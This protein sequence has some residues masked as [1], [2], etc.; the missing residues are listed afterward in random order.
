[1]ETHE[2]MQALPV[3]RIELQS[4]VFAGDGFEHSLR[5]FENRRST[6]S[7]AETTRQILHILR[8]KEGVFQSMLPPPFV[9]IMTDEVGTVLY[10]MD[11]G[12]I[13]SES[14]NEP[15]AVGTELASPRCGINAVSLAKARQK[16]VYVQGD[17]P[18][19]Q[20]WVGWAGF[21]VPLRT[22]NNEIIGFLTLF[23]NSRLLRIE[24]YPFVKIIASMLE[25]EINLRTTR[26]GSSDF[27]EYLANQLERFELTPRE[28][29]VAALWMM[30]YDYKQIGRAIG[31]SEN[32]V[33]VIT[34]RL[35]SKL[36][37][38]SKA[39]LILRVLGAI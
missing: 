28:R 23:S 7:A 11:K 18:W 38:N 17:E 34:Y 32:T 19:L 26:W 25:H 39:S 37:V 30:D 2:V 14:Q 9:L 8:D 29:Q 35:N 3:S 13:V 16:D 15:Y 4:M 22:G 24:M 1:M 6:Y 10:A 36:H 27:S 20:S 33:R 31:I 21:A 5:T 12:G